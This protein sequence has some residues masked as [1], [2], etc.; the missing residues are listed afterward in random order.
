MRGQ[1]TFVR[2]NAFALGD[3]RLERLDLIIELLAALLVVESAL[4]RA[5]ALRTGEV[6]V[7]KGA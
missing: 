7:R 4:A 1:G 6:Q 2:A 3:D 5:L